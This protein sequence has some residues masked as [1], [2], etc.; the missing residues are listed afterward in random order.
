MAAVAVAVWARRDS[1]EYAFAASDNY[2]LSEDGRTITLWVHD[3]ADEKCHE[4]GKISV[5]LRRGDAV[6]MAQYRR[7]QQESC[8]VPCPLGTTPR[9][10]TFDFDLRRYRI[11][12]GPE[13]FDCRNGFMPSAD[14][15]PQ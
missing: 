4:W 15:D 13:G 1:P 5:D 9:S 14:H 7:T 8:Q 3:P 11:V 6:V 12:P 2:R 10:Q